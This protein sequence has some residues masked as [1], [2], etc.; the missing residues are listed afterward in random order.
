MEMAQ[1]LRAL[2]PQNSECHTEAPRS[3]PTYVATYSGL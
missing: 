1:R 2:D 3:I